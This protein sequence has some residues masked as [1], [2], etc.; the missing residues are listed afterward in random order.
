MNRCFFIF[1]LWIFSIQGFM[2]Q[3]NDIKHIIREIQYRY[4][5]DRRVEVFQIDIHQK[6]DSSIVKGATTSRD[7]Y[8]ELIRKLVKKHPEVIRSE[9]HTSE[10][11]SRPHLVCRL[12]L[13]KKK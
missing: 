1:F 5:P 13:E 9:E 10:L 3:E 6:G 7:A 8:D 11:Q 4:A 12:L 2:A